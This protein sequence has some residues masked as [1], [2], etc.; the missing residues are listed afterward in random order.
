[1]RFLAA[2]ALL[3]LSTGAMAQTVSSTVKGAV[4]DSSGAFVTGAVCK[5]INPSTNQSVTV[6]S[7]SDGAFQFLDVLAG[8]YTVSVAAPGFKTYE[9][10][11]IEVLASEFHSIGNVVLQVGQATDSIIVAD[12]V[13][14]LQI[15]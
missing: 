15:A 4:Q 10:T 1:M 12:T 5:L 2:Y 14:E 7:G 6:A 3:A 8:T 9:L 11:N 13:A